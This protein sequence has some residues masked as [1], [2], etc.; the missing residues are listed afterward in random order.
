MS[1]TNPT[2]SGDFVEI[3]CDQCNQKLL[4]N[5]AKFNAET[6]KGKVILCPVCDRSSQAKPLETP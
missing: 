2:R 6:S 1:K 3:D 4:Y 5:A